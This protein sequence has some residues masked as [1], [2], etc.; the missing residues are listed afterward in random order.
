MWRIVEHT[1]IGKQIGSIPIEVLK[2]HD[3]W[4]DSAGISGPAGLR[5]IKGF[6]D[7]ASAGKWKG[8]LASR[9]GTQW[10]VIYHA[11]FEALLFQV[12]SINAHDHRRFSMSEYRPAKKEQRSQLASLYGSS[13]NYRN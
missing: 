10:R 6:H 2:R 3:T 1:R 8:S 5:L 4:K 9:L 7:E 12:A 13:G 11:V